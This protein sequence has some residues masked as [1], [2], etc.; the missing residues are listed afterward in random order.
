MKNYQEIANKCK[1]KADFCRELGI[2]PSG[3]NYKTIDNIIKDYNL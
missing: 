2:V 1:S 3:G